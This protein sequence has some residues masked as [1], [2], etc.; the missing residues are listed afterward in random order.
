MIK[1]NVIE[2]YEQN[3]RAIEIPLE[4]LFNDIMTFISKTDF[5]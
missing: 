1:T 4:R 5:E 2:N 3:E